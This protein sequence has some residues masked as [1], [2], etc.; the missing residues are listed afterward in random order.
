MA[1]RVSTTTGRPE[2]ETSGWPRR[3][4]S[5]KRKTWIGCRGKVAQRY[6]YVKSVV[7]RNGLDLFRSGGPFHLRNASIPIW[8][9]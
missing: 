4:M 5:S 3:L 7:S 2:M 8:S 9:R 6:G 1:F